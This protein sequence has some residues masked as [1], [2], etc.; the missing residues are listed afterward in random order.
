ME[1]KQAIDKNELEQELKNPIIHQKNENCQVFNGPI[2]GCVFAM[3]GSNVTQQTGQPAE[4][5]MEEDIDVAAKLSP[6]FYGDKNQAKEFL[7]AI[8]GMK[9]TQITDLVKK[10]VAA[11]KISE[12]SKN[13]DLWKVLH[14]AG[15]YDRSEANWNDQVK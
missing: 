10:W 9:P 7:A 2:S 3:P 13:R 1:E 6:I 4:Q 15:L 5:Q 14:E 11:R 12:K 8:Q